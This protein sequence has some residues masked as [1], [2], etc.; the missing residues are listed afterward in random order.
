MS[1]THQLEW[2]AVTDSINQKLKE[3]VRISRWDRD[4]KT[5]LSNQISAKVLKVSGITAGLIILVGIM[6]SF[7]NT[8]SINRPLR[9]LQDKTKEIARGKFGEISNVT[10]PPEIKELADHFNTM[11]RRLKELEEMKIDFISHVS[12]ELRTPLTAIKEASS[13][14]LEGVYAGRAD[15]EHELLMITQE[16]CE[17][18][19]D[20]VNRI[21]D[22]SRMEARMMTF[23]FRECRL[24]PLIR[25]AVQKTGPIARKK[26]IRFELKL[27]KIL[28]AVTIDEAR[29]EQVFENIV[30]N[31]LKFTTERDTVTIRTVFNP[32]NGNF[33]KV[34]IA[35][36]GPGIHSKDLG[37]I[38]DKFQRI[39]NNIETVRGSGLG[40]SIAKHIISSHGGNIW[41]ESREGE[42]STFFF[43]LP[44]SL[45]LAS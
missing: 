29:I 25:K 1:R 33:V 13:M 5:I 10:S 39:E 34:S 24:E 35:D 41:V 40:L 36:T 12:H 8:R 23:H 43:T 21:L 38:F 11:C 3:I 14:L 30:G 31:A 7:V 20:S 22:L 37:K 18:L 15:K 27:S 44:A 28:P 6:I 16:E 19:I 2:D 42:G 32:E 4:N 26:K 45:L 17:R 9:L